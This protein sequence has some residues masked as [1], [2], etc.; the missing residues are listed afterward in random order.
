MKFVLFF[1]C[2]PE[3]FGLLC[4]MSTCD[5][6]RVAMLPH[7]NRKG[8][9]SIALASC[10]SSGL[11]L[12]TPVNT[13]TLD[14]MFELC[15]TSFVGVRRYD[16]CEFVDVDSNATWLVADRL[17]GDNKTPWIPTDGQ[18][19]TEKCAAIGCFHR[20]YCSDRLF[21][22]LC[23]ISNTA[24]SSCVVCGRPLPLTTVTAATATASATTTLTTAAGTDQSVSSSLSIT[25]AA[26]SEIPS[27]GWILIG[28]LVGL[29][30]GSALTA[31]ALT[32]W[33]KK[34]AAPMTVLTATAS[35]SSAQSSRSEYGSARS[36]S[37][38]TRIPDYGVGALDT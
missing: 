12:V 19:C 34:G 28:V 31:V 6:F 20:S 27:F 36:V 5:M 23:S 8:N 16:S 32:C 14:A 1:F 26:S 24:D 2:L 35:P 3:A 11:H 38:S 37:A 29:I 13:A 25:A 33:R 9:F 7:E 18:N 10:Q 17:P 21:D 30:V 15:P 4:S 22:V